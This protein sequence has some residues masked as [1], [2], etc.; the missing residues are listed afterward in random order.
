MLKPTREIWKFL[1]EHLVTRK[2]EKHKFLTI[3]KK[4]E[5]AKICRE[6]TKDTRER[7]SS[8]VLVA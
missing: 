8:R 5:L 7:I 6:N 1:K 3:L 4:K 2:P